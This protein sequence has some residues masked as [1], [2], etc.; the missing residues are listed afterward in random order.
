MK[1]VR[2]CYLLSV[3]VKLINVLFIVTS[4]SYFLLP[5]LYSLYGQ[6]DK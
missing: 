3:L 1:C 5:L 4:A 6:M 2:E